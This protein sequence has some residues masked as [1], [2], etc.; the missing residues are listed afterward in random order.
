MRILIVHDREEVGTELEHIARVTAGSDVAIERSQDVFSA[1]G[2]LRDHYFDLAVVDLTLPLI[3]GQ[4][5]TCLSH[6]QHL[7]GAIFQGGRDKSARRCAW[8]QP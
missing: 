8:N 3:A 4:A 5:D 6:A 1:L 7:L 2:H